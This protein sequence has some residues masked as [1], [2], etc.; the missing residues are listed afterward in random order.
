MGKYKHK[1][2]SSMNKYRVV[3]EEG[4]RRNKLNKLENRAEEIK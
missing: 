3:T 2:Q 1:F 4:H